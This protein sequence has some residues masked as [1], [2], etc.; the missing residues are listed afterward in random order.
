[1]SRKSN[2]ICH[3][4]GGGGKLEEFSSHSLVLINDLTDFSWWMAQSWKTKKKSLWSELKGKSL[5]DFFFLLVSLF[6][7]SFKSLSLL[8]LL[9]RFNGFFILC[10]VYIFFASIVT[11]SLSE[12]LKKAKSFHF[13]SILEDCFYRYCFECAFPRAL[14]PSFQSVRTVL[15]KHELFSPLWA[16]WKGISS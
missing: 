4:S 12:I 8:L 10:A 15:R 9:F 7:A 14:L 5:R 6:F 11:Q 16:S 3:C 1:M 13:A 2:L